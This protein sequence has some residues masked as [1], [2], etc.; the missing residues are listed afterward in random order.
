MNIL[1]ELADNKP[2]SCRAVVRPVP[3]LGGVVGTGVDDRWR[4][5]GRVLRILGSAMDGVY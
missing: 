1:V 2:R 5:E 4:G 3:D